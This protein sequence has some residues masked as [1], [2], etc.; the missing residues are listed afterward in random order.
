VSPPI[1]PE[2]RERAA[3]PAPDEPSGLRSA[4]RRLLGRLVP[5]FGEGIGATEAAEFDAAARQAYQAALKLDLGSRA[6]ASPPSQPPDGPDPVPEPLETAE[7]EAPIWAT[8]PSLLDV[9]L[10]D[11]P[12]QAP[13]PASAAPQRRQPGGTAPGSLLRTPSSVAPVADEFFDSLIR[14]VESD[15]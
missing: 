14:R 11:L 13:E 9:R 3:A 12:G 7:A 4:G 1:D 6:P 5:R 8:R 15:R 2:G 10:A